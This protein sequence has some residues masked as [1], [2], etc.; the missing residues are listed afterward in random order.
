MR[1]FFP[2]CYPLFFVV[3]F[4]RKERAK[5][6][7]FFH[8][9]KNVTQIINKRQQDFRKAKIILFDINKFTKLL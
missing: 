2:R 4:L 3:V 8:S 1:L 7:R 9:S 6:E 5:A